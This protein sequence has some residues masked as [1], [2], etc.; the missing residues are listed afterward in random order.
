MQHTTPAG[1]PYQAGNYQYLYHQSAQQYANTPT[2]PAATRNNVQPLVFDS[3][4]SATPQRHTPGL[5]N[6]TPGRQSHGH[7]G[8]HSPHATPGSGGRPNRFQ[9]VTPR[10]NEVTAVAAQPLDQPPP[11][12]IALAPYTIETTPG[13]DRQA[14]VTGSF[15]TGN[16][17]SQPFATG[18]F[19]AASPA[20]GNFAAGVVDQHMD[21]TDAGAQETEAETARWITVY[22]FTEQDKPLVLQVFQR[23]GEI[24]NSVSPPGGGNYMHLEFAQEYH[25][26]MALRRDGCEL[27]NNLMVG[28][29]RVS[30][31]HRHQVTGLPQR[32]DIG[33]ETRPATQIVRPYMVE[34]PG[35]QPGLPQPSR[36]TWG[37]VLEYVPYYLAM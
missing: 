14:L 36:G 4:L 1:V 26:Q 7:F 29:K 34:A 27:V 13:Q 23:C 21:V 25:A 30:D 19:A 15:T 8:Q 9:Q 10:T 3:V 28:V 20:P 11:Q 22:G 24:T 5:L 37:R 32:A 16:F 12:M 18:S 33:Q 31:H 35:A 6:Q 2:H 17:A